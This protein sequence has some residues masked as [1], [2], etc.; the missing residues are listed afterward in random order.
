MPVRPVRVLM[1]VVVVVMMM[2]EVPVAVAKALAE[3]DQTHPQHEQAGGQAH[4][5]VELIGQ[6]VVGEQQ[7]HQPQGDHTGRVGDGHRQP[8]EEGVARRPPRSH[9]IR[10]D[11]GLAVAR[12][13]GMG[14]SP[15]ER[16]AERDDQARA[17]QIVAVQ[18]ARKAVAAAAAPGPAG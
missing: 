6:D 8:Q 4:P 9:Q 13:E 3:Q 11:D 16:Q 7:R 18:R 5:G 14:R 1:A 17:G 15:E 12:R 10:P 2:P